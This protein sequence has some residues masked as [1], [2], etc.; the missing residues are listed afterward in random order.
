[1]NELIAARLDLIAAKARLLAS[2]YKAGA[3]WE[4]ELNRELD[5]LQLEITHARNER[6]NNSHNIWDPSNR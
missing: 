5:E 3:L 2:N 1:M 6:G 4:G